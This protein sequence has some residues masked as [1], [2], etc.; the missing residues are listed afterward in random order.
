MS[1]P[2]GYVIGIPEVE[3]LMWEVHHRM[4]AWK[5]D[6]LIEFHKADQADL[7]ALGE[8]TGILFESRDMLHEV[9]QCLERIRKEKDGKED[10]DSKV[11][12]ESD[13]HSSHSNDQDMSDD[14]RSDDLKKQKESKSAPTGAS[15]SHCY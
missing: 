14:K 8:A 4:P 5:A 12:K 2:I 13:T 3:S 15:D 6:K 11:P 7:V 10:D 9:V 1:D